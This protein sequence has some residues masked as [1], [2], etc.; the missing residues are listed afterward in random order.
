MHETLLHVGGPGLK[1]KKGNNYDARDSA[2][3]ISRH[4]RKESVGIDEKR[5]SNSSKGK[6]RQWND[7]NCG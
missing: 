4:D 1:T 3:L 2:L 7:Q 5:N 6:L